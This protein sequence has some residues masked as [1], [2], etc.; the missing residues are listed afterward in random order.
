M[1]V[2]IVDESAARA[3]VIHEGLAGLEDCEVSVITERR[4]LVARIAALEPDIVLMDLGNPSRDVLEEYFAVS[5]VLARPNLLCRSGKEAEFVAGGEF[6][7]K[8]FNYRQQDVV[9]KRY[10]IVLKIKPK[11]DASG[12]I[13]L[14]LETEVSTIDPAHTVDG[15]PGMLTNR[16]ASY[17]DLT[18]PRTIVLSGLLKNEDSVHNAGVPGLSGLPILGPLFGSK[19]WKENRTE[20]VIFVRPSIVSEEEP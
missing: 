4:G 20:L 15:I 5:R 13:S 16:V 12:R 3:S 7:I 10:G 2:A 1:R 8:I 14:G 19:E 17:F 9:W 6:P 18:R 11:A